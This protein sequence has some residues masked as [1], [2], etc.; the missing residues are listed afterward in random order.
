MITIRESPS[1]MKYI[2]ESDMGLGKSEKFDQINQMIT[3]LVIT[4]SSFHCV[5]IG[6]LLNNFS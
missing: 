3:L 2:T 1:C 5:T 4:S 6:I